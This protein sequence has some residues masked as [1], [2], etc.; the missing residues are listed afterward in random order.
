MKKLNK[1]LKAVFS[2]NKITVI[3]TNTFSC[4]ITKYLEA[5]KQHITLIDIG[6]NKGAFYET[7]QKLYNNAQIKALLIEPIPECVQVLKTKFSGNRNVSIEQIA[8]SNAIED[9]KFFINQYDVTSSLL[10]FKNGM[11]ELNNVNTSLER[12]INVTTNTLDN[13]LI[14]NQH[15]FEIIDIIKLDVQGFEDRV[16]KGAK[17]ALKKTRFIWIEVSF[18]TLYHGSC[19]FGDIHKILNDSNFILVE[20][21]DEFRSPH[22]ELLQ[23]N[24]LYKNI[25]LGE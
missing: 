13:I 24:C 5:G 10:M 18:K 21:L 16:L 14:N 6:A 7:L 11:Q 2:S 12:S 23:A 20:I 19:L 9:K 15:N 22:N 17:E 8:V 3:D 1:I 4:K 25:K